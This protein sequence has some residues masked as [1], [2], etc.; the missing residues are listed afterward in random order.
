MYAGA[1]GAVT[2][3]WWQENSD[4][5]LT[6]TGLLFVCHLLLISI[7]RHAQECTETLLYL[8]SIF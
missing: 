7:E 4:N 8:I 1:G 5:T 3:C 6:L 2:R